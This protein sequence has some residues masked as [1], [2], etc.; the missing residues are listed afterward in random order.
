MFDQ[1]LPQPLRLPD[2]GFVEDEGIGL[3]RIHHVKPGAPQDSKRADNLL[4]S[5]RTV[6][7]LAISAL[8]WPARGDFGHREAIDRPV[9]THCP[10]T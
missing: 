6:G 9:G 3:H 4:F 10:N 5:P 1:L 8:A 2:R 7:R